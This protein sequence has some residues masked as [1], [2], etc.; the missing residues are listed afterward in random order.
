MQ[1]FYNEYYMYIHLVVS[2]LVFLWSYRTLTRKQDHYSF[3]R[4]EK[5]RPIVLWK[6]IVIGSASYSVWCLVAV[7][8][9]HVLS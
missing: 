7:L 9:V 8:L 5:D 6:F 3:T 1:H 2:V 4:V